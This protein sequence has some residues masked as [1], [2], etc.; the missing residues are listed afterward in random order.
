M[1]KA[2]SNSRTKKMAAVERTLDIGEDALSYIAFTNW[3]KP[4]YRFDM[5]EQDG[6]LSIYGN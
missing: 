6:A 5:V 4:Y 2:V 1:K 3:V